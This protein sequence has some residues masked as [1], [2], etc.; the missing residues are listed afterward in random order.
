MPK[1]ASTDE[2]ID[3]V[4]ARLAAAAAGGKRLNERGRSVENESDAK[5]QGA[6][7]LGADRKSQDHGV[8]G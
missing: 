4:R 2:T 8:T 3:P 6:A 1:R 7:N 5:K